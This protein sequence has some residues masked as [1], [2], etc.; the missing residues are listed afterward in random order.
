M[1]NYASLSNTALR[2]VTE[3][4]RSM[5]LRNKSEGTYNPNTNTITGS[6]ATDESVIG[7]VRDYSKVQIDN[8]N[9]KV[10]DKIVMLAAQG[11]AGNVD[12][13]SIIIDGPD[14][15]YVISVEEIKPG[16]TILLYTLQVRR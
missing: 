10:G 7:V 12:Q 15:W 3:N 16:D 14:E 2:L 1:V 6:S 8:Q 11:I 13:D 4:G 9:I 5:T